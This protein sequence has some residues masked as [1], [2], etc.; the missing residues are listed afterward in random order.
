MVINGKCY[1]FLNLTERGE[2]LTEANST[3][4]NIFAPKNLF[5][6][7]FEPKSQT[8]HDKVLE[9]SKEIFGDFDRIWIG[10]SLSETIG[11]YTYNSDNRVVDLKMDFDQ[12]YNGRC[13]ITNNVSLKLRKYPCPGIFNRHVRIICELQ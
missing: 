9:K 2:S 10:A 3:C 5:A 12:R 6:K 8:I 4:S 7:I 13:M 1:A 11:N